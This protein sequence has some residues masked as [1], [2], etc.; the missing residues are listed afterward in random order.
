[1]VDGAYDILEDAINC[2]VNGYPNDKAVDS[3]PEGVDQSLI[4][5]LRS[6]N[7]YLKE[8]IQELEEAHETEKRGW[9]KRIFKS[10]GG[11]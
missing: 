1:M 3:Q 6:E 7:E 10:N 5:Q 11:G 4:I 9:W 8:R 2:L